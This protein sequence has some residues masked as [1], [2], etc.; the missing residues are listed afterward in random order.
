MRFFRHKRFLRY[1]RMISLI[2]SLCFISPLFT[3]GA[4]AITQQ[5]MEDFISV[6]GEMASR[7]M[8]ENGIL[9]SL[10]IAQAIH[11]SAYGTSKMAENTNNLFGMKAFASTWTGRV[12]CTKTGGVYSSFAE[13]EEILGKTLYKSYS[14]NFFRVYDSW[15]DSVADH[16][17]LFVMYD[18]YANLRGLTDYKLAAQYVVEDGYCSDPGYADMII[19]YIEKYNLTSYDVPIENIPDGVTS[20]TMGVD[21]ICVK[22]GGKVTVYPIVAPKDAADKTLSFSSSAAAV[23]AVSP[24]GVITGVSP[25]RAVITAKSKSGKSGTAVVYVTKAGEEVY[26]AVTTGRLNCRSTPSTEGGYNTVIGTFPSGAS[27]IVF[28]NPQN[29]SWYLVYGKDESGKYITGYSSASLYITI[30]GV[31]KGD[32]PTPPEPEPEPEPEPIIS[33][34]Y[35]IGVTTGRL[36]QRSGPDAGRSLV[37]TFAAGTN[38]L[39]IGDAVNGWY[40]CIGYSESGKVIEGYS[41]GSY[42]DVLGG[43]LTTKGLQLTEDEGFITGITA[44]TTV[45]MLSGYM[46]Y[47]GVKVYSPSGSALKPA[48][49]I[50]TGS[51]V[52]FSYCQ[53]AYITKT[54]C[55]KGDVNGD[56]MVTTLDYI[57]VKLHIL[58]VKGL[59]GVNLKAALVNGDNTPSIYDYIKVRLHILGISNLY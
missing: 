58:G 42:I 25:G 34:S 4:A 37:G 54:L 20:V 52:E 51:T 29:S 30:T 3:L 43:F 11:E 36:N 2:L 40:H 1:I 19:F 14:E 48:D 22:V 50:P 16:T 26:S 56:G 15:A 45:S 5:Q 27:L 47:A 17:N 6:I 38:I 57:A 7:D 12:Y 53:N 21:N 13:A 35:R 24:A 41:G 31:F 55:V 39:L 33:S 23:A 28:G 9:A 44:G 59:T 49:A 46:T 18:R 10:T 8:R 32:T